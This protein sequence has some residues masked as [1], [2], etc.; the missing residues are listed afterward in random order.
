MEWP[1]HP[2]PEGGLGCVNMVSEQVL[3]NDLEHEE[4]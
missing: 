3:Y 4:R 1:A 2:P